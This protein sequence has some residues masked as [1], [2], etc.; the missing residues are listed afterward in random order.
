[1]SPRLTE[2]KLLRW[3][4]RLERAHALVCRVNEEADLCVDL[5]DDERTI[6]ADPLIELHAALSQVEGLINARAALS[7]GEESRA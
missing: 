5:D 7:S 2:A 1:M 3:Q 4:S 6:I